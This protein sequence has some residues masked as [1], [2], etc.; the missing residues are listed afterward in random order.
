[1]SF[2]TMNN[3]TGSL[4]VGTS[5]GDHK[6]DVGQ[7]LKIIGGVE[8]DPSQGESKTRKVTYVMGKGANTHLCFKGQGPL[9]L[10]EVTFELVD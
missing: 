5:A 9:P 7:T 1:M 10:G 8:G 4:K 2:K 3:D 6:W